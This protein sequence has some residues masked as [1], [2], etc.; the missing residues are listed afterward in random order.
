M[1]YTTDPV[2]L[3]EVESTLDVAPVAEIETLVVGVVSVEVEGDDVVVTNNV[4]EVGLVALEL[5]GP[6]LTTFIDVDAE[7]PT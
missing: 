6:E 1:V 2:T 5:K 3:T 4:D 7:N